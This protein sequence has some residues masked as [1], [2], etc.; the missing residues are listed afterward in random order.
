MKIKILTIMVVVAC[1]MA[2]ENY[3]KSM[4]KHFLYDT[5]KL[6][7]DTFE[8]YISRRT[9]EEKIKTLKKTSSRTN[10]VLVIAESSIYTICKDKIDR[11]VEDVESCLGY[12]ISL[13][14][15]TESVTPEDIKQEILNSYNDNNISGAVLIGDVSTAW[16]EVENDFGSY[17]Y[18]VFPI[19]LFYMDLDGV[20][21]DNDGNNRY[22]KH[23][24]NVEPEIFIGRINTST[25]NQLGSEEI[26]LNQYLD[27]NHQFWLGNI[28]MTN[29]ISLSYTD[30]DWT[31]YDDMKH[32]IQYLYGLENHES[33]EY[34]DEFFSRT[35]YLQ[36][37]TDDT[38][39]MIQFACH[40][41]W[42][43][44]YMTDEPLIYTNNLFNLPPESIAYNLFCCSGCRWTAPM[45]P[46]NGFLGGAYVYNGGQ[47]TLFAVG[48]TKTGSMLGFANYYIPLGNGDI[49][50]EA[51]KTWWIDNLGNEHD[52]DEIS[53]FYGMT[54]VGDPMVSMKYT[55]TKVYETNVSS[56]NLISCYPNPFNPTTEILFTC[57]SNDNVELSVYDINGA[58]IN[59][60][61]NDT[62]SSGTHSVHFNAE[63]LSSG[64]YL[65]KV[66]INKLQSQTIKLVLIK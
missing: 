25:M 66:K 61:I 48:S 8:D 34:G 21:L 19:D 2:S 16:Y 1:L 10:A 30:S 24:N 13:L 64:T 54:I 9:G 12:E 52:S 15:V 45:A 23:L 5:L 55:P 42:E 27:K 51:M 4:S 26:L 3:L 50:G 60:L 47:N 43:A 29:K 32:D 65:A 35:D 20:W 11:Y 40:S 33:I 62:F 39:G 44:H 6:P 49:N 14:T 36:K 53:W 7:T 56:M 38:Y 18:A 46:D 58:H 63:N 28:E 59:T 57:N 22:D 31:P 41:S 17:G 37:V